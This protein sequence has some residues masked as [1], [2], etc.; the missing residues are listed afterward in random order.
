MRRILC[1]KCPP[2]ADLHPEDKANGFSQR[3]VNIERAAKPGDL[4]TKTYLGGKLTETI[5]HE[6]ILCD[7]C[8]AKIANGSP[9]IAFTMWRGPEPAMWEYEYGYE[10][11]VSA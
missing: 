4:S 11:G 5:A 7:R 2:K 3:I 10:K 9:C 8:G 6:S 1:I